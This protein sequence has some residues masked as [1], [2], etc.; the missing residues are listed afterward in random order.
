VT[1][2]DA[3]LESILESPNDDTPRL[4][5]ADYLDEHFET[6]RAKFIR[7]QSLLARLRRGRKLLPGRL[8]GWYTVGTPFAIRP[9]AEVSP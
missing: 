6:D 7:V 1:H 8:P 2:H 9:A 3:F 5:Y 4:I